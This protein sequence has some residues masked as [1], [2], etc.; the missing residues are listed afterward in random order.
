MKNK[1]TIAYP[2]LKAEMS[3]KGILV[4]DIAETL[5]KSADWIDWRMRGKTALSV[6]D[7]M[8]IKNTY[9]KEIPFEYLFSDTAIIPINI[10]E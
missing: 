5:G 10:K 9:F 7:A 6:A 1:S 4:K 8:I 3:R 2:N